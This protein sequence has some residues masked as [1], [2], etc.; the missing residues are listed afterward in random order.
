MFLFAISVKP[1]DTIKVESTVQLPKKYHHYADV[2][3]KVQANTLPHH[4]PYGCPIDVQPEKE[5]P[6]GPIYNLSPIEL[7][8][9]RTYIEENLEN[10]FIRHLKSPTGAPIFFVK[11]KDGSLRLVVDYRVLNK[12]TIRNGYAPPYLKSFRAE[13]WCKFLHEDKLTGSL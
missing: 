4:R 9:L 2:F 11:K 1:L 6:W 10:G 7:Q 12:V 8:V 13:Q 3:D 5:P